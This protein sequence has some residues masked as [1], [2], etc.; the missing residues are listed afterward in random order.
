MNTKYNHHLS[1]TLAAL[2]A[3]ALLAAWGLLV[4]A[5]QAASAGV[6]A[7]PPSLASRPQAP[8]SDAGRGGDFLISTAESSQVYPSI[9]Y[10]STDDEYLV[11]WEDGRSGESDL[12]GQ[13]LHWLGIPLSY[14]FNLTTALDEQEAPAIAFNSLNREYLV[15]WADDRD[16]DGETDIWG[17]RWPGRSAPAGF[18]LPA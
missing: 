8:A 14:E 2:A 3:L 11:V 7:P 6:A 12:Y 10:N 5:G 17:Q 1:I 16:G 13:R 18:S 4:G 9:A 15:A